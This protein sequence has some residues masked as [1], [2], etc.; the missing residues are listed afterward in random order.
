MVK[1][2]H[3]HRTPESYPVRLGGYIKILN[4]YLQEHPDNARALFY[5]G[6][7]YKDMGNFLEAITHYQRYLNLNIKCIDERWQAAYDI[8]LCWKAQ[9][10][11]DQ[12]LKA[13]DIAEK[14]DPRRA[15]SSVLCGE[16]YFGLQEI[17]TAIEW[18][19]KASKLP[20]PTSMFIFMNPKMYLEIPLDYLV[21]CYDKKKEYGHAHE[22]TQRLAG[23]LTKPD[24]RISNNL[25]WLTKQKYRTIFFMLG[26][27]PETVYG[28]MIEVQGVGGVETTYLELPDALVKRGHNVYVFCRCEKEHI[29]NGV[30]F[31]PY[32]DIEKYI[33]LTPDAVIT[34]RW[35][36]PLY[37]FPNA[38][39]IIWAQ[40]AH[41]SD[42]NHA[43]A[44]QVASAVVCSSRWHRQYI[45]ER[46]GQRLDAKKIHIIPLAIRKELF[47]KSVQRD[48]LKMIYSSNPDRGLYIL[49]DTWEEISKKVQGI[50]LT[51][52]YGWEG[53]RTWSTDSAWLQKIEA[54]KNRMEK[55]MKEA[56][57]INLTGRLTKAHLAEEML[58]SSLCL[59]PNNFW[60]TFCLTALETQA[61]GTPMITTKIGA[62]PTTLTSV[63]NILIEH[64][65]FSR[66]YKET[67][68]KATLDLV[69]N[70]E[71]RTEFSKEC[72]S[73]FEQQ[74]NW[75]TVAQQWEHV[76]WE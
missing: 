12:C 8:A 27:T 52:T 41:F 18:F 48:P 39:K 59:Y 11:Y 23:L 45:A 34:S 46:L 5:L 63:G 33:A 58:S 54:D 69:E 72:V 75:D 74:P 25:Y 17:D 68:I 9:G 19:E 31:I 37:L 22:I 44:W 65:P 2:D 15:E 24:Q 70:S 7:T 67:F 71:K 64:N 3:S 76:L 51:I 1:H 55:W 53:L 42:P 14:I 66:E 21:L 40:D 38:K 20:V 43:D 60:E 62:L 47:Q 57:N 30:Y 32:T 49:A 16:I 35:Y 10:E 50:R 36:D 73:Y 61:A 6:R 29:Y 28:G 13:C 26:N 56:G 4:D